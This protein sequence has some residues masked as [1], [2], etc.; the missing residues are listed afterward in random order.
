MAKI[1]IIDADGIVCEALMVFLVK[2]GHQAACARDGVNG[3][4]TFKASPPDLVLLD[5]DLPLMSGPEVLKK[6]REFSGSVPVF[7]MTG[8]PAQADAE[9]CLAAGATR[10]ISKGEGLHGV[11]AE[12]DRLLGKPRPAPRPAG[13]PPRPAPRPEKHGRG[14]VLVAD[15]DP[16]VVHILT[17]HLAQAGYCVLSAADGLEAERLA[18]EA[19]PDIILLDIYMPGKD[20]IVLL[21]TLR[22]EMPATGIMVITGNEDEDLARSCLELGAF[23]YAEKPFKLETLEKTIRARVLLQRGG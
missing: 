1:L 16:A 21:K 20:G 17:R 3:L 12:V 10:V 11:L 13:T 14:L 5:R 8:R 15:D 6:I 19:R 2:E 4:Q 7:V 22:K 23:D 18:H 9:A